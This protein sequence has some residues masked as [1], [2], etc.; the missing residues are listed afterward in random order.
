MPVSL[1]GSPMPEIWPM[2]AGFLCVAARVGSVMVLVPIPGFRTAPAVVR[3]ALTAAFAVAAYPLLGNDFAPPASL[4]GL[5]ALLGLE[6][7]VGLGA[8]AAVALLN[9][10][11]SFA[12]QSLA[13]QAGYAYA[14]A[15]DPNTQ[16]DS[17]VLMVIAQLA[18]N[19]MF[20]STGM[21]LLVFR[22]FALSLEQIPPGGLTLSGADGLK[23]ISLGAA[24]LEFGVRLAIPV[25]GVLLLTDLTLALLGRIQPNLQLLTLIFPVKMLGAL[26]MLAALAPALPRLYR[27][28]AAPALEA[29]RELL[30]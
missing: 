6:M 23:L 19:L 27:S 5:L 4:G 18:A 17:G 25:M 28:A 3:A 1:P 7:A 10:V 26:L 29:V 16:A 15:I 21:Y 2:L 11:F 24:V 9:E 8:G 12:M 30:R 20:F 13:M 14:S 22:A